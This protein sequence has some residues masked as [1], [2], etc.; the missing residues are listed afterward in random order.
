MKARQCEQHVYEHAETSIRNELFGISQV[1]IGPM[2]SVTIS[3]VITMN[4]P[5]RISKAGS[6]GPLPL[7][8]MPLSEF[9]DRFKR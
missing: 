3:E 6:N 8:I 4:C 2:Q 1:V 9:C 7:C 5:P